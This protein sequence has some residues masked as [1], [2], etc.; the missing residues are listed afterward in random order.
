MPRGLRALEENV[1]LLGSTPAVGHIQA[2]NASS[3]EGYVTT[4]HSYVRPDRTCLRAILKAPIVFGGR[5]SLVLYVHVRMPL[6]EHVRFRYPF[7]GTVI[8]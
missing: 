3:W 1:V 2:V 6:P 8:Q 4:F 5:P 7:Y